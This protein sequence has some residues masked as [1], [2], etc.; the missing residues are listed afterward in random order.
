MNILTFVKLAK[1]YND[2]G[3]A[4]QEQLHAL[5]DGAAAADQN[6]AA[7]GLIRKLVRELERAGVDC[8]A[9][10]SELADK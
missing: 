5:L 7:L 9:I 10:E 2:L 8:E 1:A 3:W 4:V 6:P